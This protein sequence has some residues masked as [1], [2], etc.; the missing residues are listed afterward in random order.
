VRKFTAI[1]NI[2]YRFLQVN[3]GVTDNKF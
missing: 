3:E 2:G 1:L